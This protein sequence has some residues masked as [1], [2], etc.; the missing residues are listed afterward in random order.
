MSQYQ[1]IMLA[2]DFGKD[3]GLL[4]EKAVQRAQCENARLSAIH[5]EHTV[6]KPYHG[7]FDL[8][9]EKANS[10]VEQTSIKTMK[11]LLENCGYP[12]DC[13][14][15]CCDDMAM[16]LTEA[17][18]K[19]EVDL[20]MMGHHRYSWLGEMFASASE[21]VVRQMPCDILLIKIDI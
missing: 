1:H 5:I 8:N 2:V 3:V 16:T 15:R 21:P 10:V 14:S 6:G 17:V 12:V 18:K 19:Y 4:I 20:L 7:M 9:L 11:S 13:Y